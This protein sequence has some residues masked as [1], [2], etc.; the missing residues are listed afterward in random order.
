M[1][2]T[3][4]IKI[5]FERGFTTILDVQVT[6]IPQSIQPTTGKVQAQNVKVW[7]LQMSWP[8]PQVRPEAVARH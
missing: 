8:K 6:S 1:H 3:T 4:I 5:L 2:K 7:V